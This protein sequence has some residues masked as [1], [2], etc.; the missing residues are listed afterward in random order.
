[1]PPTEAALLA[2]FFRGRPYLRTGPSVWNTLGLGTTGVEA[3]PL[4][5]NTTQTGELELGGRRFEFRRVSFPPRP[6]LEYF[7]VDLLENTERAGVDRETVQDALSKAVT[8]GRFD[9]ERL[10]A[11]AKQYG[12]RA[13]EEAVETAIRAEQSAA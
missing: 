6:C 2:A 11:M 7:V 3:V 13:T 12:T 4:V 9:P 10:L 5:Y 8:T 1:V